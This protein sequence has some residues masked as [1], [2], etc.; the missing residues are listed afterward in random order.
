[1]KKFPSDS[2]LDPSWCVWRWNFC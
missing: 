1:V 2:M